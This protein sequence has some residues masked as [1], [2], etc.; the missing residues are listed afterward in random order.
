MASHEEDNNGRHGQCQ[1]ECNREA[2]RPSRDL[3]GVAGGAHGVAHCDDPWEAQAKKDVD[4]VGP[5]DV[6][7]ARVGVFALLRRGP[8]GKRVR[9]RGACREKSPWGW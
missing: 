4:R 3:V 2:K 5:G 1:E 6:A 9:H 8:G 7:D